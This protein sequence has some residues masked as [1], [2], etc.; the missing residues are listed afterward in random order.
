[1]ISLTNNK[2]FS[3]NIYGDTF[4]KGYIYDTDNK[5]SGY[6]GSLKLQNRYN[7]EDFI[8]VLKEINGH[9]AIVI[10]NDD[11]I[12]AVT[13]R[14]RS[15]PLFY[16]FRDKD[17]IISDDANYMIECLDDK[18]IDEVSIRE[19]KLAGYVTGNDTLYK[20]IKQLGAG[21]VLIFNKSNEEL[22]ISKYFKFNHM[23][24]MDEGD[25]ELINKLEK[26]YLNVF[27]RMVESL[28]GRMAVIPLSGGQD[29]RLV[30]FMLKKLGYENVICY[31]YGIKENAESMISKQVA[32]YLGYKW[33]F[34]EYTR[35]IWNQWYSSHEQEQYK[36]YSS[37]LVSCPHFQ[38]F[39]AIKEL[40]DKSILPI[41]SVII[42]GHAADFI[43]GSHIP[44]SFLN[45]NII[46]QK[47]V[48][49]SILDNHYNKC[50]W[51]KGDKK[52]YSKIIDKIEDI[53][54]ENNYMNPEQATDKFEYWEWQERQAKFI[55]NSVR[56]Y[57]FFDYEW[58][59]P[60]WDREI[61]EYWGKVSIDN[62]IGRSLHYKYVNATQKELLE[63][64]NINMPDN[65]NKS[66]KEKIKEKIKKEYNW[67][68]D[69][70]LKM[71]IIR[72][73]I[74]GYYK[75]P[76]QWYGIISYH[77]YIKNAFRF[78][79]IDSFI[80]YDYLLDFKDINKIDMELEA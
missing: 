54:G 6:I 26:T 71:A 2:G 5:L 31:S 60:F 67:L 21:E 61:F 43:Q 48:I 51:S 40:K 74:F 66:N 29:S 28:D 46:S 52:Y 68:Y 7:E 4:V 77:K 45:K 80:I 42:P 15:I 50:K 30:A 35:A 25:I 12:F 38:D 47:V 44:K 32:T 33:Y 22:K 8:N 16:S 65:H 39:L 18:S 69:I 75:D 24:F 62:R 1:M 11:Y 27:S 36:T 72:N 78:N 20:N 37:N 23:N 59:L 34:V 73:K 14:I 57:E 13:D 55:A 79:N 19:F 70:L 56:V 63:Y 64:L 76:L 41:D 53:V 10:E 17:L 49:T 9:Y 3:W 58:R